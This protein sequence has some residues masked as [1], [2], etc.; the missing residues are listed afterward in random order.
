ML[1][2]KI[3]AEANT[4]QLNKL[5]AEHIMNWN[6][7]VTGT[8][9]KFFARLDGG[10]KRQSDWNPAV[11]MNDC[12]KVMNEIKK[13]FFKIEMSY[14]EGRAICILWESDIQPC[15]DAEDDVLQVA[16]CRAALQW[17]IKN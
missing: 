17:F 5:T 11:D 16:C 8:G 14:V 12:L 3:I 15:A 7:V 9:E 10:W 13:H 1:S 2:E 6:N 4:T